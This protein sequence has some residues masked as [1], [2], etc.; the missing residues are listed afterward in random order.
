MIRQ[1]QPNQGPGTNSGNDNLNQG[2]E[3]GNDNPNQ[4]PGNNLQRQPQPG[5]REQLG[6][7]NPN[8]AREQLGNDNPTRPEQLG[9]GN[10]NPG[11]AATPPASRRDPRHSER[12]GDPGRTRATSTGRE[13]REP[14]QG[15]GNNSGNDGRA[16]PTR[17][18]GNNWQGQEQALSVISATEE[19]RSAVERDVVPRPAQEDENLF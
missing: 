8:Q 18:P 10:P 4:G 12:P 13:R 2:P 5:A 1:R 3:P 7:A 19:I 6:N 16:I 9:N 14:E 15:S 17:G 11:Q